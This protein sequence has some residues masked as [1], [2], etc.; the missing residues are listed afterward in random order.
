M[1]FTFILD[2]DGTLASSK[3]N[4]VSEIDKK[5]ILEEK[6]KGNRIIIATGRSIHE[7][8]HILEAIQFND[9][10]IS[11]NGA[12]SLQD[13][14][15]LNYMPMNASQAK[16]II[17]ICKEQNLNAC[18]VS[19]IKTNDMFK[20]LFSEIKEYQPTEGEEFLDIVLYAKNSQEKEQWIELLQKN[21]GNE[22]I[23]KNSGDVIIEVFNKDLNKG[24]TLQ[25]LYEMNLLGEGKRIVYVGDSDNDIQA[26]QFVRK[27]GGIAVAMGNAF[28]R[29][30]KEATYVTTDVDNNGVANAIHW[31]YSSKKIN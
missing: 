21:V 24:M 29:V 3:R 14:K 25:R 16:I 6:E 7:T 22:L 18:V 11:S 4:A 30:K 8:K 10:L 13:N 9:I 5:V 2:V 1:S 12:L 17:Q 28:E 31:V 27:I 15:I 19:C 20:E 26:L 23:V